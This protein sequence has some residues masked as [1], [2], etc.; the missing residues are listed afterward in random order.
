MSIP[1]T[2]AHTDKAP[3]P[4]EGLYSQA[5]I[6]NGVVYCS[7]IVAIDPETGKLIDGDVKAHTVQKKAHLIDLYVWSR[8][9][10][11]FRNV[12][13]RASPVLYSLPAPV[14]TKLSR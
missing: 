14:S 6:A 2:S 8:R 5:V 9:S 13:S 4:Y 12:S 10:P 11:S 1:R 3:Q 7:G